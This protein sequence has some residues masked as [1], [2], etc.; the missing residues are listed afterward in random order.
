MLNSSFLSVI[1]HLLL[2]AAG[3]LSG[4]VMFSALI[5]KYFC[6]KDICTLSKDGNPGAGNVFMC[7]GIFMGAVCLLLDFLKGFLPVFLALYFL[8]SDSYFFSLVMAA[9]V[10]G[11]AVAPLFHFR[12]GKCIA[13]SFGVLL[14]LFP[15]SRVVFLLAIPYLLF[16]IL[17]IGRH[18]QRSILVY[19]LF[20]LLSIPHLHYSKKWK[21]LPGCLCIAGTVIWRHLADHSD[22][23]TEE[24]QN[25]TNPK[26][27]QSK[28]GFQ[29]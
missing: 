7:C 3:F 23:A 22:E 16:T 25:K 29:I 2:D 18:R 1:L 27:P 28:E 11:H 9:P 14:A 5:P 10:L 12:G 26:D 24:G 4:S 15:F 6:G 20:G 21:L 13:T 19:S 8:G 17:R